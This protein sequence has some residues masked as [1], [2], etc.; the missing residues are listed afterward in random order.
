MWK[1]LDW[2]TDDLLRR[3][4]ES[5]V[6]SKAFQDPSLSQAMAEFQRNPQAALQAAQ[7]RPELLQF[8]KEFSS[9]MGEH[10]TSLSGAKGDSRPKQDQ[11]ISEMVSSG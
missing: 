8:L 9:L 7:H 3:I 6:L 1:I 10:F 2:I 5:P 4:K 11:L